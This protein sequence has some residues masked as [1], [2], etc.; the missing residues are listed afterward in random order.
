MANKYSYLEGTFFYPFIFDQKDMFDRY[1]LA[2]GLEGDQVK[3]AK[4]IGLTVKQDEGKTPKSLRTWAT[5]FR[6]RLC[7]KTTDIGIRLW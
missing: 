5:R 3:A 6:S 4:N 2:L 7:Q 1:S